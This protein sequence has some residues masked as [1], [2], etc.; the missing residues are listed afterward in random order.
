MPEATV[1]LYCDFV[2]R[3]DD[4]GRPWQITSME[5]KAKSP[6]VKCAPDSDFRDSISTLD[7][8]HHA[9]SRGSVYDIHRVLRPGI[10]RLCNGRS[11]K[12]QLLLCLTQH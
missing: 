1:Y 2:F 11:R 12:H 5:P 6:G 3:E 8:G 10:R 4:V 9:T 7:S